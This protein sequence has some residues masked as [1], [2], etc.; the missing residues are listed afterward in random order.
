ME[1]EPEKKMKICL[2]YA[3]L[4]ST[5]PAWADGK[6]VFS[7][8]FKNGFLPQVCIQPCDI[9]PKGVRIV[10]TE[11][12]KALRFG[13]GKDGSISCLT[14]R[15]KSSVNPEKLPEDEL[16]FPM[17]FGRLEF[18]FRPVDWSLGDPPFNMMLKLEGPLRTNL[19]LTY[20]RPHS[21]GIASL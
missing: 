15:L 21:T 12:G 16:P 8:D 1:L 13:K 2:I 11:E 7:C 6:L 9:F 20:T 14:Y 3:I 5:L 19:H 4:L 10:D 18:R 17:R